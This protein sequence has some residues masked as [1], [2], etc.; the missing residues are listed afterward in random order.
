[1][2]RKF[3]P[4]QW[5]KPDQGQAILEEAAYELLLQRTRLRGE[6]QPDVW[7]NLQEPYLKLGQ[8]KTVYDPATFL[9][10]SFIEPA[11]D[12][13]TEEVKDALKEWRASNQQFLT[14]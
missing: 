8:I 5:E 11:N 2:A 12:Y 13:T 10:D 7:A 14:P 1:M 6:P 9:D 3:V 4:E